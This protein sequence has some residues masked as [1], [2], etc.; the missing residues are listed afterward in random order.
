MIKLSASDLFYIHVEAF[1]KIYYPENLNKLNGYRYNDQM[2]V[3]ERLAKCNYIDIDVI[4]RTLSPGTNV[5]TKILEIIKKRCTT[6]FN[7][8]M[9]DYI[10]D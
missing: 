2:T 10:D 9:T 1:C 4:N 6:E 7:N 8:K 5:A 3:Y